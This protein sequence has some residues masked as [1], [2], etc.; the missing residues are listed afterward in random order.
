MNSCNNSD[1]KLVFNIY[2]L[3]GD[4]QLLIDNTHTGFCFYLELMKIF[5]DI[6]AI[7]HK[8]NINNPLC[9]SAEIKNKTRN[10]K[11]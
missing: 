8:I 7:N 11:T 5:A 6:D 2:T 9:M 10:T 1:N 3:D 4:N